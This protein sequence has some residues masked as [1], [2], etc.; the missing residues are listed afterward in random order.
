MPLETTSLSSDH[1]VSAGAMPVSTVCDGPAGALL[2]DAD[3]RTT[4]MSVVLQTTPEA[5]LA[6]GRG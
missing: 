4:T 2:A 1:I 6:Q 3:E 5:C